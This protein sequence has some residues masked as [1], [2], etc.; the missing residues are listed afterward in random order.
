MRIFAIKDETLPSEATLAYLINFK[1]SDTFYIEVADDADPLDLPHILSSFAGRNIRTID[2]FWSLRWVRC[3]IVPPERQNI[4]QIIRENRLKEYDEFSLLLRSMGRCEQDDC[5]LE[6]VS[7]SDLPIWLLERWKNR[8]EEVIP[9]ET[10][11]LLVLCRGGARR[12]N[13]QD[14]S[15]KYGV[16][17]SMDQQLFDKAEILPGGFGVRWDNRIFIIYSDLSGKKKTDL[18]ERILQKYVQCRLI[19]MAEACRILDCSRQNIDDLIRRGKLHPVYSM[20]NNT[21]FRKSEITDRVS[22]MNV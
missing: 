17:F 5:Y 21:L 7:E 13:I 1:P 10:P 2:P 18:S 20:E 12:V 8:I 11:E 14:V 16:P 22:I 9:L 6:E 15:A 4:G 3:R 19:S